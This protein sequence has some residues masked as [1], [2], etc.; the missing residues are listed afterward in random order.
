MLTLVGLLSLLGLTV[1]LL[2]SLLGIGGGVLIIP[3]LFFLFP[4]LPAQTVVG[5]SL[6]IILCVTLAN[7][8][9]YWK[10][11]LRPH[12]AI[13]RPM[14]LGNM[15]GVTLGS[16]TNQHLPTPIIKMVF[17][18]TATMVA[19]QMLRTCPLEHRGPTTPTLRRTTLTGFLGGALAGLT[20]LGGGAIM[21]PLLIKLVRVPLSE[22]A[23]Y[24][25][26]IMPVSALI[27][28]LAYGV[29][30]TPEVSESLYRGQWGQLNITIALPIILGALI[31]ARLGVRIAR[32]IPTRG[33]SCAFAC[34]LLVVAGRIFFSLLRP[35]V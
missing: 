17:A 4:H 30:P 23:L 24:S 20:G 6:V 31:S 27:G 3:S 9:H 11:G 14:I 22:V 12:W 16:L 25:N 29:M 7:V 21:I 2:S 10:A 34:L 35:P 18:L 13:L 15:L 28:A 5:T 33:L 19:L 1:G 32:R 26:S 8:G